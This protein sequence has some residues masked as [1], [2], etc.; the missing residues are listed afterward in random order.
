VRFNAEDKKPR[1]AKPQTLDDQV[2]DAASTKPPD[3]NQGKFDRSD[4]QNL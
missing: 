1:L 2:L 4:G 3:V